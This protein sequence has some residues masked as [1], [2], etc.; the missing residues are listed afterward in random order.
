M[1][2]IVRESSEPYRWS[3]GAAPLAE[4]ALGAKPM[5]DNFINA[6]GNFVTPECIAY[7][8]PL[9]GPLPGYARL[10]GAAISP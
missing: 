3:L 1:V 6:Q 7:L 5:P 8:K 2:S 10:A 4:V 9:V